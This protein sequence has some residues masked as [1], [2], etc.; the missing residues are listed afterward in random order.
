MALTDRP[1]IIQRAGYASLCCSCGHSSR[2]ITK[3]LTEFFENSVVYCDKTVAALEC[4]VRSALQAS[5]QLS[6][7]WLERH[8]FQTRVQVDAREG[9]TNRNGQRRRSNKAHKWA[10]MTKGLGAYWYSPFREPRAALSQLRRRPC[11]WLIM[12]AEG[13]RP[14]TNFGDELSALALTELCGRPV[15]WASLR[16]AEIFAIGSIL[17]RYAKASATGLILGSGLRGEK[18]AP[19]NIDRRNVLAVRGPLTRRALSLPENIPLGDPGLVVRSAYAT[20][21]RIRK[22]TL[23]IPHYTVYASVSGRWILRRLRAEGMTVLPP[24]VAPKRVLA[25]I[26]GARH[27]ATSSLHG[28]VVS[29]GLGTPA[30]LIEFGISNE[31]HFK[32]RDYLLSLGVDDEMVVAVDQ[33]MEDATRK[34]LEDHANHRKSR[35]AG[36]VDDI[37]SDLYKASAPLRN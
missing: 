20:E 19:S 30:T 23:V 21:K 27:V 18:S 14:L 35:I 2:G 32:Y 10:I 33:F 3:V 29:D 5:Q 34:T 22:G 8:R 37:V 15:K 28:L 16:R 13:G 6:S 25:C 7:M 4:A 12:T 1:R 31:P 26:A 36:R 9:L 24:S 17:E 11:A